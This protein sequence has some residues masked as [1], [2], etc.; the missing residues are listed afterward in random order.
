MSPEVVALDEP[1]SNLHP[2]MVEQLGELIRGLDATVVLVSQALLPLTVVCDRIAILDGG[3]IRAVGSTAE[4][5]SDRPLLRS[6]GLDFHHFHQ[7]LHELM[8]LIPPELGGH[9]HE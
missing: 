3:K 5:L 9:R 7:R 1:F 2:A 4:I 8:E 6:C